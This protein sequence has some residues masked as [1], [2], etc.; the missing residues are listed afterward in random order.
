MTIVLPKDYHC[1]SA[2][3]KSRILC[4]DNDQAL[5]EDIRALRIGILNIMPKAESYEFSLLHPLG[6]SIMQIEPVWIK[7]RTHQYTSSDSSHLEK[8]YVTFEEAVDKKHLDGLIVT[9]APVEEI[10]FEQ[11]NYWGEIKRILKYAR[12]N[13]ASTLGICWGGLALAKCM[14]MEKAVFPEKIFGVYETVNL[15]RNHP[16]TGE[17]DDKFWCAQ[18]RH[19]GIPDE[20]LEQERDKGNVLLLAYAKGAGYTIFESSDHRFLIHLGHPE[21]EPSRLVE[22]YLRDKNKGRTDVKPPL[23]VDLENPV[24]TWRSHRTEFF[25]QWIKYIH[26]TTTY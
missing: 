5:K 17:M 20:V 14:D 4:I 8:L 25:S 1:K 16:V 19:A 15:D 18:S 13:I 26:E 11:V 23:N 21:Y 10:P 12:N 3:E 6:R 7:L 22:E 24:N 9:G 2:L